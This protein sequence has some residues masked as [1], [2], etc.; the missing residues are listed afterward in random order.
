MTVFALHF[1]PTGS[2]KKIAERIA[3]QMSGSFVSVDLSV[4]TPERHAF[5]P[6]D[7]AVFALPVFVGRI[8]AKAAEALRLCEG[9]GTPAVTVAVFGARAVEDALLETNDIL[10]E[11]GFK[12][13]ASA[14]FVAEHS[15]VRSVAA[16]RPDAEDLKKIDDFSRSALEKITRKDVSPPAVPGNRPYREAPSTGVAPTVSDACV[17]CGLCVRECPAAA[18]PLAAPNTT[19]ASKCF[20]CMRC[21][22]ICPVGAR[23]LPAP[24]LAH[25]SELL[26]K[27]VRGRTLNA[28]YL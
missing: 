12:T 28:V 26:A 4:Q 27:T 11:R 14:A 9:S 3:S 20:M 16:G 23:S 10:A 8:P 5:S 25:V 21:V 22:R 18:I 15:V 17:K 13:F 2:T 24:V 7:I 19:D 1:S 6:D